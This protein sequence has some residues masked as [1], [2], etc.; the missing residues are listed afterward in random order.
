MSKLPIPAPSQLMLIISALT[1]ERG[2][3]EL[4]NEIF[5]DI[6]FSLRDAL[7]EPYLSDRNALHELIS[8]LKQHFIQITHSPGRRLVNVC[9]TAVYFETLTIAT[10]HPAAWQ[11]VGVYAGETL[12]SLESVDANAV[13]R[14]TPWL[15]LTESQWHITVLE[16]LSRRLER[17]L[18]AR[19]ASDPESAARRLSRQAAQHIPAQ[20][21]LLYV[22]LTDAAGC[23][24]ELLLYLLRRELRQYPAL[25]F[26]L[27]NGITRYWIERR[28]WPGLSQ[29]LFPLAVLAIDTMQCQSATPRAVRG[30][31]I[32]A[33]L[34]RNA[35][36][37]LMRLPA[38]LILFL[39][40]LIR[41]LPD[42]KAREVFLKELSFWM[43]RFG[44]TYRYYTGRRD[45]TLAALVWLVYESS[46]IALDIKDRSI[47]EQLPTGQLNLIAVLI[48][49]L[50]LLPRHH[51]KV[52]LV[53]LA[54]AHAIMNRKKKLDETLNDF[55]TALDWLN[56][57]IE[58]LPAKWFSRS[59]ESMVARSDR[60]HEALLRRLEE[61]REA[62]ERRIRALDERLREIEMAKSS[63]HT[64]LPN[65]EE[66]GVTFSALLS[67]NALI[68]EG[69]AMMHCVG[70]YS[71]KCKNGRTLIYAISERD[72]R[73]GTL[74]MY[75]LGHG[76]WTPVQFSGY[77]N[78]QLMPLIRRSGRLHTVFANFKKKLNAS[79]EI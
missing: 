9:E 21:N 34:T 58:N 54:T 44:K 76:K 35:W 8:S 15:S 73:L 31:L 42:D 12:T 45:R 63:W 78:K 30:A 68:Q 46:A 14:V 65:Y 71:T 5:L 41:S 66:N 3:D 47:S 67:S 38:S 25:P 62:E 61:E 11:G 72:E 79:A 51:E 77:A 32:N 27:Q 29:K 33:G 24:R 23:P 59:F 6:T 56:A 70:S 4:L 19:G 52:R 16:W 43:Q 13:R 53:F 49:R 50:E 48:H 18:V 60:W 75:R 39:C 37:H 1:D 57:D 7:S 10:S 17:W 2:P 36:A 20:A 64:H 55:S 26:W 40:V 69:Q 28:H 22:I 74:E